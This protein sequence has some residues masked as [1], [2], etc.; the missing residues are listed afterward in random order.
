MTSIKLSKRLKT[1]ADKVDKNSVIADIGC[2]HALL[3]IYL[4]QNKII[5]KAV[6]CDITPGVLTV[7]LKNISLSNVSNVDIRI[8]NGLDPIKEEDNI[9]TLILSGLGNKTIINILNN[10]INKLANIKN[11]IIQSNT[12]FS[13]IRKEINKLGYKIV[14][15]TLVK[16]KGI[17]Y[18]VIK[19]IKSKVKYSKKELYF[20][21]ILLNNKDELFNELLLNKIN[22]YSLILKKLP[23]KK[24]IKKLKIILKIRV[25]K[26]EIRKI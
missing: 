21:P 1:I 6:A 14:D 24:I 9:D 7:A 19:F 12:G 4:S 25:L 16:E 18:V 10:N 20:G 22:K 26:K 11:I 2:D 17:I 23:N 5:K 3:D 13:S 15:E 8:G